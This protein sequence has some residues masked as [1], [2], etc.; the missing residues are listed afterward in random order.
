MTPIAQQIRDAI[1]RKS[2]DEEARITIHD[3]I[4]RVLAS[5]RWA[6]K[7][8]T[9]AIEKQIRAELGYSDAPRIVVGPEYNFDSTYRVRVWGGESPWPM[10]SDAPTYTL[11]LVGD[12]AEFD[13]RN[14]ST[15]DAAKA[16]QAARAAISDEQIED[17]SVLASEFRRISDEL[18][19]QLA[20]EGPYQADRYAIEKI[21]KGKS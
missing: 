7:K 15:G 13:R 1:T 11:P 21:V 16:R 10:H 19:R 3:A 4:R 2:R 20:F 14:P 17:L 8:I 9:R 12:P 6:G 18:D 5:S